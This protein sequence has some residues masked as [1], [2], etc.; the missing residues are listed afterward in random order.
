MTRAVTAGF[1][2]RRIV[3][4]CCYTRVQCSAMTTPRGAE[5]GYNDIYCIFSEIGSR[6][7]W[8]MSAT[9]YVWLVACIVCSATWA[10][11]SLPR[12]VLVLDQSAPLRPWSTAIMRAVQS[13]K[14][15]KSGRPISYHV[16]HLDLF[17]FG[18]RQYDGNLLSHLVDKYSD[19]PLVIILSIGP[20]ALDFAVKLRIPNDAGR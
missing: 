17:G 19:K 3:A 1:N 16:E 8:Q 2:G 18:G 4:L 14:S 10:E 20:S 7:F 5:I 11:P 9:I 6:R 13:V 12:S 15:D